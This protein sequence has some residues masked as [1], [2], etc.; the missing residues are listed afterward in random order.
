MFGLRIQTGVSRTPL[1]LRASLHQ[2]AA[3]ISIDPSAGDVGTNVT[4]PD[5]SLRKAWVDDALFKTPVTAA[6][7]LHRQRC[8]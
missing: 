1:S 7:R 6:R 3:A 8:R 2:V 5:T 4:A